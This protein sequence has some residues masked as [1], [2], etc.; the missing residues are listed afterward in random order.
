VNPPWIFGGI[1]ASNHLV[2]LG[3]Q[4]PDEDIHRRKALADRGRHLSVCDHPVP[5]AIAYPRDVP[6]MFQLERSLDM[7][8]PIGLDG[9]QVHAPSW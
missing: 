1:A 5:I 8:G 7:D 9:S 4:L 3:A 6:A 2:N